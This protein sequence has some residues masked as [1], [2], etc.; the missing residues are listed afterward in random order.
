MKHLTIRVAWH[1]NKWNGTVCNAPSHNPFCVALDRIRAEKDDEAENQLAGK[2][3]QDLE[4]S[5]LP[6]CTAESGGFMNSREWTRR[7]E[8]PYANR[9]KTKETH[10][11]LKPT[12][13]KVPPYSTFGVPFWWMLKGNQDAIQDR[14]T[15][16]LPP[17]EEA[18]FPTPWVF[19]KA[20]QEAIVEHFFGQLAP[21]KSLVFFYTK[22]GQPISDRINRLVVGMGRISNVG[23]MQLYQSDKSETYPFWDRIIGHSIRPD[24]IDGFLLPYHDYLAPTGDHEEDDRRKQLLM[25]IALTVESAHVGDY[26]YAAELAKPDVAL[27]S[28]VKALN[29]VRLVREHGIAKGSWPQRE[30]WLNAQI[31]QVWK[32]RGAFPGIGS[33]LEALGLRLGTALC[34]ELA[35]KGSLVEDADPWPLMDAILKGEQEPPQRAYEPDLEAVRRSWLNLPS[36]RKKL[37]KLLSRFD[38]SP[39]Q[40][41]R[42]FDPQKRQQ[43]TRYEVSDADVL[44][45]PYRVVEADLGDAREIP[46]SIGVIDRGLMPDD[47]ITAKHPVPEPSKV[48]SPID[49]RRV[50]AGMV[51]V[52]R[53]SAD[54]GDS[55]L[56]VTETL[57]HL[58]SLNL[59]RPID[60]NIDWIEA[61]KAQLNDIIKDVDVPTGPD[62][63]QRTTAL[64]LVEYVEQETSLQ[65]KLKARAARALPS[66]NVDWPKLLEEAIGKH[67]YKPSI[68]RHKAAFE[69]QVRALETITT[70][71]VSALTGKAGTGKTSV[72]GALLRNKNLLEDGILL[73]APTG[74]ARVRLANVTQAKAMTIA[75][76]LYGLGRY[77]GERQR[78]KQNGRELHRK[79]KT[80]IID[81]CSMLT[82]EVL[83]AVLNALD[84]M[85][86]QRLILV[87]DP[88]QLPPIGV[89]RPFA[90]FTAF[91]E[92]ELDKGDQLGDAIAKLTVEVRAEHEGPS[93]TLRLASWFTREPQPVDADEVLSDVQLG[94]ALRDLEITYWKTPEQLQERM[95]EQFKAHLGLHS[96]DDV[97]RFNEALGFDEKG[98]IPFKDPK[99]VE[100]FQILSPVRMH[101]HGVFAL[102]RWIQSHFRRKEL[103]R[104]RAPWGKTLGDEEIVLRDKVIQLRNQTRKGY[105]W[106]TRAQVQ[107]YLAN[108]EIGTVANEKSSFL[109]VA[110]ADRPNMTFGYTSS[111]FSNGSGPLELA[112][113]L[114]IHKAQGSEFETVFVVLPQNTRLLSRELLYTALTRSR[115]QL[116]LFIEGDDAS[117]LFDL[118]KPE[119]SDTGRRNTNLFFTT[120][121]QNVTTVPYAE[122]LIHRVKKGHLVRSKS[123]VII[124]NELF[125]MDI[126]YYYER[127]LEGS[128]KGGTRLPDFSI[129]DPAGE[130]IIWEH[131]GL[132][133][134]PD[135]RAGW[136]RK[137][138]WYEENGFIEGQNLFVTADDERGGLDAIEIEKTAKIIKNLV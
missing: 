69:E 63:E 46:I 7:F 30:E 110:F 3:W 14:M 19:G 38:L 97:E 90:D 87:G 74:K 95:L 22:E 121:R 31:A 4:P 1:D 13:V 49:W 8:H 134:K 36:E 57:T 78:V 102:N 109:N 129:P 21:E 45:N 111:N 42:W 99:G 62:E 79:E 27:S 72:L 107:D 48:G 84:L 56:S 60:V 34:Q 11:H 55:L 126:D 92:R 23:R 64:Q 15:E 125:N 77:D 127:P 135:Y 20:R 101:P 28:L 91:L 80:V 35:A 105:N 10:G 70:R 12:Y 119:R 123:E 73:L 133:S 85:H 29:A 32:Q 33:S 131:L 136:E 9:S 128:N 81:E 113:A 37:L 26:S 71:K 86:V 68:P 115:R 124:A 132:L 53:H 116:V 47:T 5:Q 118:T 41:K 51:T 98:R 17:D 65:K 112:Y 50:R 66:L 103:E 61:N 82:L 138:R 89:G 52:L 18:P 16:Q 76:F 39:D 2:H 58:A 137:K 88:N 122:H 100:N 44:A 67:K 40:A 83:S 96:F 94:E 114:T 54:N 120:V 25:E 104:G 24:G 106:E 43:S 117:L 6:P 130:I 75:Q 93:D 108:G 59:A